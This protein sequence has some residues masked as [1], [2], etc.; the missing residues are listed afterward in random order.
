MNVQ[1]KINDERKTRPQILDFGGK[2]RK[3]G[4]TLIELL[5]VIAIIAILAAMLLPALARSKRQAWNATC[6]SNLK[7]IG[8]VNTLYLGDNRDRF[9][10]DLTGWPN[11]PFVTV[12]K[13]TS[14]YVSTNNR[15]FYKCPADLGPGWNIQW[16]LT[17]GDIETNAL[18]FP[19]SYHYYNQFFYDDGNIN[20]EQ[21]SATD[22]VHPAQKAMWGCF[23]CAS[24]NKTADFDSITAADRARGG[25]GPDGMML[26]FVDG[27]SQ[28]P[29]WLALNP[30]SYNG[31]DPDYNLDW[32]ANGLAGSDLR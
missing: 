6:L 3:A 1:D 19:C 32:T 12:F 22:V 20:A 11:F 31:R 4:F 13:L 2:P 28:F 30:T 15:S 14:P 23:A 5:V 26:L 9:A 24:M 21:R 27:H 18:P 10:N 7:Q 17:T 25:H 29:R 16:A 8:I